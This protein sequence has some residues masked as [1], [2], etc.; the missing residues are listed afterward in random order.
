MNYFTLACRLLFRETRSGELTILLLALIIAVSSSTAISLFANRLHRTM[1]TQAAEFLAADLAVKSSESLPLKWRGKAAK[2]QLKQA[3]TTEFSSVLMENDEM[4][5]VGVKAVSDLYPLRGFLK[6]TLTDFSDEH[7]SKKPP[8]QGEVWIES[9]VLSSLKLK[10]GDHLQVGE[11]ALKVT[12]LLT[13]EPDKR[14][15]LY[16][17][18]PRVMMNS[19]DLAA[20][21]VIQAGSHIHYF[22]QFAGDENALAEFKQWLKPQ[23][24]VSQRLMDLHEDRPELGTA[25]ERAE[26]YLGLASIMVILI[27]GVAIAMATR[28]YSERH[29]NTSA[30]LRCLGCQQKDLLR[31]YSYQFLLLGIIASALGCLFGWIAQEILLEMLRDLLP[32]KIAQPSFLAIVL[33]FC[34]GLV[35]LFGFAL[36]PL[37]RLKKVSALR[38]LRHELEPLPASAYLVYGLAL[39]LLSG[40]IFSYTQDL[41][42]TATL[43][44]GGAF[45]LLIVAMILYGLLKQLQ[46]LLPH[47]GLNTR[48]GVQ[49][50]LRD[51]KATVSQILAFSLTLVAMLLSFNVSHGLIDD[52]QQQLPEKTPNHF[53]LNIFP[54]QTEDF[55]ATLKQHNISNTQLY[56]IVRGR[57]IKINETPVQK[58]VSKDSQG[59]RATHRELSLTWAAELPKDNQLLEGKW[60]TQDKPIENAVSIESKLAKSLKVTLGDKLTFTIGSQQVSAQVSS[61]RK[62]RWDTMKPNFYMMFSPNSLNDFPHTYLTSFYLAKTEK[63]ILNSLVKKYPSITVL[64]V[65]LILQQFK[66]ILL[67]LTQAINALLY[68]ALFAG[69]TVLFA[70]VYSTLDQRIYQGVLMRT[71]GANKRL[72]RNNQL[73][74]FSLL[75]FISGLFAVIISEALLFSLYE[76]VLKMSYHPN[77]LFWGLTPLVGAICVT[78]A[79]GFGVRN[80]V[81]KSPMEILRKN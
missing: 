80:V 36:P 29:F 23:L 30:V 81:K 71:L 51:S 25:L 43:I 31:L 35:I 33:G 42:M 41:K 72:L 14:G 10:L 21:Q 47:L 55:R 59:E 50:L 3:Q 24:S 56:P 37:L 74:E 73:A 54:K 34:T 22:F 6:T 66:N 40:L 20:T 19:Q 67:Q 52:W 60:W 65:D 46:K 62:V 9:R 38:V 18:S 26:R 5:L 61:I 39:S 2:L 12:R 69:F 75:G 76:F 48:F 8:P 64:E 57:L 70:A 78:M 44:G 63:N 17:L 16:S 68:F 28:R 32:S 77:Y 45:I 11:K 15:N 13:Y 4:L 1:T 27:S 53:I 49:A 7:I 58:I 79:G